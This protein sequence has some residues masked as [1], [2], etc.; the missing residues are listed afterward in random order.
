MARGRDHGEETGRK[1]TRRRHAGRGGRE[2]FK[3]V[4]GSAGEAPPHLVSL[5]PHRRR[6]RHAA[7]SAGL[8]PQAQAP[9]SARVRRAFSSPSPQFASWAER[10]AGWVGHVPTVTSSPEAGPASHAGTG[11]LQDRLGRGPGRP[12]QAYIRVRKKEHRND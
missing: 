2:D 1:R 5:T 9:S 10:V 3:D 7:E 6:R 12:V 11:R 8:R 4:G